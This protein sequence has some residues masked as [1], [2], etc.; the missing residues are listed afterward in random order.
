MERFVVEYEGMKEIEAMKVVGHLFDN[1]INARIETVYG[2]G[3][4]DLSRQTPGYITKMIATADSDTIYRI[5]KEPD[6]TETV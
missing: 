1:G 3:R 4:W 6:K 5:T 2:E